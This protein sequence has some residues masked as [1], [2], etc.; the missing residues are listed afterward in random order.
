MVDAINGSTGR[1]WSTEHKLPEFV[2][3]ERY[4]AGFG[5]RLMVKDLRTAVALARATD[6]PLELGEAA[7][8]LWEKAEAALPED[9]DHTEIARWLASLL[10]PGSDPVKSTGSDPVKS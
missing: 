2:I 9:A 1:S 10:S 6:T 7:T 8:A 4:E 3:P 5:L